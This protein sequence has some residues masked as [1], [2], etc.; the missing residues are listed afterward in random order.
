MVVVVEILVAYEATRE[1][2]VPTGCRDVGESVISM[3]MTILNEKVVQKAGVKLVAL[4][5]QSVLL[6]TAW[7]NLA[8]SVT[9]ASKDEA[10]LERCPRR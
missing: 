7:V 10:L 9:W 5:P 2:V 3:W 8:M 6:T 4:S 1:E